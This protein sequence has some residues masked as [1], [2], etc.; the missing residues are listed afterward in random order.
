M[1]RVWIA[2]WAAVVLGAGLVG[3]ETA[4][5][6]QAA[7]PGTHE[8]GGYSDTKI[9]ADRWRV[10]FRGNSL[11]SRNTVETYLLYRAAQLTTDQGYDW[12][13]AVQRH[14]DKH[15]EVHGDTF[16]WGPEW[17]F[18]GPW[19][20]PGRWGGWGAWGDPFWGPDFDIQQVQRYEASVEIVMHHGEKPAGDAQAYDARQVQANLAGKIV[21]PS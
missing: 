8:S 15:T 19:G 1:K 9:E 13:E 21:K 4:T 7:A 5:P 14:T 10:T 3:C 17:R 16:G 11:T 12:F 6:Y 20:G 2:V 18:Y